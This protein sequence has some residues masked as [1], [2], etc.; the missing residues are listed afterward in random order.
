M[1]ALEASPSHLT[2]TH[3]PTG[4][5]LPNQRQ[6]FV[7]F[8][9]LFTPAAAHPQTG[10][11]AP[12]PIATPVTQATRLEGAIAIDGRIDEA[13]WEQADPITGFRQFEP[14][15]GAPAAL[16]IDVRIL[17][18]DEAVYVGA[19]MS[20]PDGVVA[21]LARRDQLLDASGNNG[22]F[23]SLTTDKLVVS[24]DPY[25][26]HLD[27]ALFEVN[28]AGVRGDQF[29]GDP[30]WDPI[31][32]ASARQ[33]ADGWTAEMRIPFS[34]LRFS[35]EPVQTWGLQIWRYVDALNERDMWS[36][37]SQTASGGPSFFG[38]LAALSIAKQP[39]QLELLP[40]VV[41]G[42]TFRDVDA[43]NPYESS[44]HL[45][46]GLGVDLKYLLTSNLTLDATFNPDFG[47]VEVDPAT[48]N[49][50]A[51]ETFYD[52]KR[53]FFIA[54]SSAF[55]FGGGRCMFCT[56]NSGISA[57]Y[58][59][60][61]GRSPQLE[62]TV[63]SL[64]DYADAPD[65][66][67]ILGAAKI[68][69][70]TQSGYTIGVLNAVTNEERARYVPTGQGGELTQIVEPFA[71]YFVTRVKKDFRDGATT[72]GGIVTSTARRTSDPLV[73][74]RLRSHAEALGFDWV[75][76]WNRRNYSWMG[77]TIFSNI[78]GSPQAITRTM[79]SSAHYF[80]RPDRQVTTDGLFDT[81][82]DPAA[83]SLRGYGIASRLGK[84]GGG[85]LRWEAMTNIRS[86]GFEMNDLSFLNRGDWMW[87]NGNV[88]G[89]WTTPAS[90]YRS[91][92]ATAGGSSTYNF[93]GDRIGSTLQAFSAIQFLNYWNLRTLVIHRPEAYDDEATRGGPVVRRNAHTV[94]S[95]SVS[96]DARAPV[97]LDFL[98]EGVTGYGEGAN[99]LIV[100]PGMAIKP[101]PN[102]FVQLSPS[103]RIQQNPAQYVT[104]VPDP[105]ADSFF[106]DRYV[107]AFIDQKILSL[108]T[109]VNATF[110][111]NLTLQLYAQPFI[112]SGNYTSF[113]EFAAPRSVEKLEYGRDIGT[114]AYDEADREYSVD[115]DA[116][117]PAQPFTF[118]DPDFTTRSLRG[119]AVLRWEYR[120]GSTLFFVWSQERFGRDPFDSFDFGA[121]RSLLLDD[122]ATN[123][124]Q[125]KGTY[126]IG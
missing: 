71:N 1:A 89:N 90:W 42:S 58:S 27:N 29:N 87:F 6:R 126:W 66:T 81:R 97:V 85:V 107:F 77:S 108:E 15:E 48:L 4:Q 64:A 62:G 23:N 122:R 33:D 10:P 72:F 118:A 54:G 46:L 78:G 24:L 93:D 12:D 50:T 112:A 70:R 28:P 120:P 13:A 80:H 9:L 123:V 110:T 119:T 20:Q 113:R 11:S 14:T 83:I 26:N 115:P 3:D 101:T 53:P 91:I 41:T 109:R 111:P 45:K 69:G 37:W 25:H 76:T 30:S 94:G 88:G 39:K 36:F 102:V 106:G 99:S 92:F 18:D 32:E 65:N 84:D 73:R 96:T 8:A 86:P 21:P 43:G 105:T 5:M 16:P 60:R 82:Y 47:Q 79:R 75:H 22:S 55:R 19:R 104:R 61:I 95:V 114:I 116:A 7:V 67:S 68:T 124:F 52:E 44:P 121:A 35:D 51:F 100:R 117:G 38:D 17:Y 74:D 56:E 125:I 49:L 40:Y 103:F 2:L 57:F 34:Q 63:G 31:W 98:V 59:R